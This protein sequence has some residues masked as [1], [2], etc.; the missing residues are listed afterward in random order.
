[1]IDAKSGL[2]DDVPIVCDLRKVDRQ[3]NES[4]PHAHQ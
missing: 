3:V 2:H 1:M 4:G